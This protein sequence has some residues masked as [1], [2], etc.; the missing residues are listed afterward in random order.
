VS[1]A[2]PSPNELDAVTADVLGTG[3]YLE[4]LVPDSEPA[5]RRLGDLRRYAAGQR[6]AWCEERT[7]LEETAEWCRRHPEDAS[8]VRRLLEELP[9]LEGTLQ[10]LEA[11][12][13]DLRDVECFYLKRFCYL[14]V[15]LFERAGDL[16]EAHAELEAGAE[17]GRTLLSILHPGGEGSPRFELVDELDDELERERAALERLRDRRAE[18]RERLEAEVI[19]QLGGNFALDGEYR[20]PRDLDAAQLDDESRLARREGG[21]QLDDERLEE[22]DRE[23]EARRAQLDDVE[24]RVRRDLGARLREHRDWIGRAFRALIE[25][26]IRCAKVRLADELDACWGEWRGASGSGVKL[27]GGRDPRIAEGSDDGT[28]QPIDFEFGDRP[29]VVTGPNMGGKSA[30]LRLVGLCQWCAQRLLPVPADDFAFEPVESIVYVG[31]DEPHLVE[32]DPDLS[33][34]GREIRRLVDWWEVD[35]PALWLL[36]EIGRGTHP[37]EGATLAREIVDHLHDRG[38]RLVV[39]SHFPA[40]ASHPEARHWR[41]VGLEDC[42]TLEAS[43]RRDT[44]TSSLRR[45]LQRLMDYQPVEA[46]AGG[47]PREARLVARALGLPLSRRGGEDELT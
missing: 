4:R 16:L 46:E 31:S 3:D 40:V 27:E 43:L 6:Q 18:R 15:R 41:I 24:A 13:P 8:R 23:C 19:E 36:D 17:H 30:L 21:W 22:L 38:H 9:E 45:T 32:D 34:F 37:E 5:S 26:D 28:V 29:A 7:R 11:P 47:V 44:E 2:N 14:A 10:T 33:S 1:G 20:P 12:R 25:V 39:A 42:E 35:S